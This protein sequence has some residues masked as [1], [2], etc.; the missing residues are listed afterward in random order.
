MLEQLEEIEKEFE[1]AMVRNDRDAIAQFLAED[2]VIVG[3]DG[4]V[5]QRTRF[6]EV[7]QAGLLVHTRM[8]TS[9]T[10]IR[11]YGD[12][13]V[14]TGLTTS[15]GSFAGQEFSNQ[16]RATSVYVRQK[17]RLVCVLT[18]LT[19]LHNRDAGQ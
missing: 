18:Q 14:V 12:A 15:A 7:I 5:I 17:G 10:R 9:E 6:L 13:A 16:E 11:V 8:E 19:T 1:A 3:P 2:W 4:K